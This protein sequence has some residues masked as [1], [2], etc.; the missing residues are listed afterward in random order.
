[1]HLLDIFHL[2]QN[3]LNPAATMFSKAMKQPNFIK[4][5][6]PRYSEPETYSI[7]YQFPSLVPN[8]QLTHRPLFQGIPLFSD[9]VPLNLKCIAAL[10]NDAR[11]HEMSSFRFV[12]YVTL[13]KPHAHWLRLRLLQSPERCGV[14]FCRHTKN[15][16]FSVSTYWMLVGSFS[17]CR[18]RSSSFSSTRLGWI[19]HQARKAFG[20]RQITNRRCD[21]WQ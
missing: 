10:D 9:L 16:K 19:P 12:P 14:D 18:V 2:S 4:K 6:G 20:L 15:F 5:W 7:S 21:V 13:S 3:P 8:P 11:C 17:F 1:M